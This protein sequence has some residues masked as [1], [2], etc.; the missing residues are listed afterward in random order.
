VLA[1]AEA[2]NRELASYQDLELAYV[3]VE[4][5]SFGSGT[6]RGLL[7]EAYA[8]L[9]ADVS[10]PVVVAPFFKDVSRSFAQLYDLPVAGFHLDLRSHAGNAAALDARGFPA[11]KALSLGLVDARN[12]RLESVAEV[13]REAESLRARLPESAAT[14]ATSSCGLELLPRGTARAKLRLLSGIRDAVAGA[15]RPA[16][17]PLSET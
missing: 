13:A 6:D 4:E 15:L 7:R 9:L 12:T 10:H 16:A 8:A 14:L 3:Q 11:G 2:L 17:A 5:P 1:I